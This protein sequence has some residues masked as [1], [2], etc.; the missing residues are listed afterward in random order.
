MLSNTSLHFF[1]NIIL[2]NGYHHVPFFPGYADGR[3]HRWVDNFSLVKCVLSYFSAVLLCGIRL[4]HKPFAMI[5]FVA[6]SPW[7]PAWLEKQFQPSDVLILL[8][9]LICWRLLLLNYGSWLIMKHDQPWYTSIKPRATS[10]YPALT[11]HWP[12][13]LAMK[14]GHAQPAKRFNQV[15]PD[16][17]TM[18]ITNKACTPTGWYQSVSIK[19]HND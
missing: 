17:W 1:C 7:P 9:F 15:I 11:S 16:W 19:Q 18:M 4:L 14:V 13:R 10:R 6:G 5:I 2:I 8:L 3:S 12:W